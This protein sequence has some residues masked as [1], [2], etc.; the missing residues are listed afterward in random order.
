MVKKLSTQD[1]G[2]LDQALASWRHWRPAPTALPKV[3]RQLGGDSNVSLVVTDGSRQWVLRLNNSV[4]DAGINRDNERLALLA[5]HKAGIAP[6]PSF[7]SDELLVTPF[8]TGEQAALDDLPGIGALFG[9]IHA[10]PVELEPIDL[11]QHLGDY[12]ESVAPDSVLRDC[13]EQ[14]V[15]SYPQDVV[16]LKPCHNDCLLPN[17]VES[18]QG[19]IVLDWEYAAA[20]DPAFDLGVFC[21]T[22]GLGEAQLESLLSAYAVQEARLAEGLLARIRYFEKYYRLIEILW[23]GS[24]GRTMRVELDVLAREFRDSPLR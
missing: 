4:T 3:V 11:L 15:E 7:L 24:R 10:L 23:W 12:Y 14:I 21:G 6:R 8:I 18:R 1:R 5:G 19:L 9:Q 20:A 2:R 13:Y 22:Y 17:I 16:D